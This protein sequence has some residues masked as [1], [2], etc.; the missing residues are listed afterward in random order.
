MMIGF[1]MSAAPAAM[2]AALY[3]YAGIR[4]RPLW[5]ALRPLAPEVALPSLSLGASSS[6]RGVCGQRGGGGARRARDAVAVRRRAYRQVIEILDWC[7][8][9]QP[10]LDPRMEQIAEE[11]ADAVGL[12]GERRDAAVDAARIASALDTAKAAPY[13]VAVSAAD[14]PPLPRRDPGPSR[15]AQVRMLVA[16]ARAFTRSPVVLRTR[17]D[18]RASLDRP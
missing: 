2:D 3:A 8:Y 15:G 11:H 9:L 7:R 12:T 5:S 10:Y 16:I 18:Y 13:P 4:L 14:S 6:G 17:Q 1:A